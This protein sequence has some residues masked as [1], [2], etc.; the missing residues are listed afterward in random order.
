MKILFPSKSKIIISEVFLT[1]LLEVKSIRN[2]N[3]KTADN[4]RVM[5][6]VDIIIT[7]LVQ[8]PVTVF[9]NNYYHKIDDK[10]TTDENHR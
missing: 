7:S 5:A 9:R 2:I 1:G 8:I 6:T 3:L 10:L 4:S